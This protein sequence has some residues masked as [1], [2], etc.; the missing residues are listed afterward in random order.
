[1]HVIGHNYV[2]KVYTRL[3]KSTPWGLYQC[4]SLHARGTCITSNLQNE[5][6]CISLADVY[7]C[8]CIAL[9]TGKKHSVA[10]SKS[11]PYVHI[12]SQYKSMLISTPRELEIQSMPHFVCMQDVHVH[13]CMT[14]YSPTCR[15]R[16][17]IS[18]WQVLTSTASR[19]YQY[20]GLRHMGFSRHSITSTIV[21]CC[22]SQ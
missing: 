21:P 16:G 5:R 14:L 22:T 13:T 6:W 15:M 3:L 17:G 1:M 11:G 8:T 9:Q 4:Y 12:Y 18:A 10:T 7:I 19:R 2:C 20:R